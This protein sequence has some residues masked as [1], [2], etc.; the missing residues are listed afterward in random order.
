MRDK[1]ISKEDFNDL[2]K[3][4]CQP[5][6]G[7]VLFSKDGTV[8]KVMRINKTKEQVI[9]SSIA[10]IRPKEESMNQIYLEY[11][12]KESSSLNQAVTRKSGSAIR[13]I[14]LKQLKEIKIIVPPLPLQEKFASI[15]KHVEELKENVKKTKQNSEELFNSL[16][17]KAFEGKL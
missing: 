15:V 8:G 1:K 3:N 4:D 17:H 10:I 7:D 2:V 5:L 9:L 12:L 16:M 13:R 11:V 6:K 14:I